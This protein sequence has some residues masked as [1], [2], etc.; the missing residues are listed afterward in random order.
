MEK[1]E[2]CFK[3]AL[4]DPA[5][6]AYPLPD[7][8]NPQNIARAVK[9]KDPDT[10][11][12]YYTYDV[13]EEFA[14]HC[15]ASTAKVEY[16]NENFGTIKSVTPARYAL[17]GTKPVS[18]MMTNRQGANELITLYPMRRE[19]WTEKVTDPESGAQKPVWKFKWHQLTE[20]D[21]K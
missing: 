3:I 11:D 10:K 6:P 9:V 21:C 4:I 7:F 16:D 18:I 2:L 19:K 12:E 17:L 13:T 14:A 5:I 8:A 20:K 15:V 1:S